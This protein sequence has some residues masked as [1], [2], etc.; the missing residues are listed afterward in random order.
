MKGIARSMNML[1]Y[2]KNVFGKTD[3]SISH[4]NLER[5]KILFKTGFHGN[6]G[7][8]LHKKMKFSIEDFFSKNDQIR[9]KSRIWSHLLK[10]SLMENI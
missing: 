2:Q 3:I 10:K 8:T 7:R 5:S 6:I 1:K 9:R 4:F